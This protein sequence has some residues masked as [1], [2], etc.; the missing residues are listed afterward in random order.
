MATGRAVTSKGSAN[1]PSGPSTAVPSM[2]FRSPK[3]SRGG[4]ETF[5]LNSMSATQTDSM[6]LEGSK[7]NFFKED[8]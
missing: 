5:A 1:I 6:T 3:T 8:V 7:A 2:Q 4:T